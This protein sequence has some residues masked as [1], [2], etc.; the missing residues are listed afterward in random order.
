M[1]KIISFELLNKVWSKDLKRIIPMDYPSSLQQEGLATSAESHSFPGPIL[2]F[3]SFLPK[4]AIFI[5][6]FY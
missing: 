6:K 5:K 4:V 2:P 1:F 3:L